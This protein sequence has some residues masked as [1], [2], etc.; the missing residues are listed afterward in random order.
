MVIAQMGITVVNVKGWPI[1]VTFN[2]NIFDAPNEKNK[3]I[4]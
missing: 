4:W 1:H 2:F 3:H